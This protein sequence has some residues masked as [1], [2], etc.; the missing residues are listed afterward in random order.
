MADIS[1]YLQKFISVSPALTCPEDQR[2]ARTMQVIILVQ[3]LG[4]LSF[5]AAMFI[6]NASIMPEVTA[7]IEQ[8][9]VSLLIIVPAYV[10]ARTR[11][12]VYGG[13]WLITGF[14]VNMLAVITAT[15]LEHPDHGL[16][17]LSIATF[18]AAVTLPMTLAFG[19]AFITSLLIFLLPFFT[20]YS[21]ELII[22]TLMF[23]TSMSALILAGAALHRHSMRNLELSQKRF[24]DLMEANLESIAVHDNHG[25]IIDVNPAL[26]RL[27]G[28]PRNALIN[29]SILEFVPEWANEFV[30]ELL[31]YDGETYEVEAFNALGELRIV[32]GRTHRQQW[33]GE[34]AYITLVNDI[35]Q[36]KQL[37]HQRIE[38]ERRYRALFD[39]TADAV[40]IVD[41]ESRIIEVN[42]QAC[43][44]LG[45]E[46]GELIHRDTTLILHWDEHGNR[47][48]VV[49]KLLNDEIVPVFERHFVRRDGTLFVG[50]VN[51]TV[52][53]DLDRKPLYFQNIIRDTSARR[54]EQ[55]R[56][57]ELALQGE[58]I[59][60]LE[61]FIGETSHYFR[62]P[63]TNLKTSLYLLSR[64]SDKPEK[65][66]YHRQVIEVEIGRLE[67]LLEDM[68]TITRLQRGDDASLM[69]FNIARN[70]KEVINALQRQNLTYTL[71]LH[72][73]D[74]ND[75]DYKILGDFQRMMQAFSN[76]IENAIQYS[77]PA[78]PIDIHFHQIGTWIAIQIHDQGIGIPEEDMA[79]IFKS[80]YRA[81]NARAI[82]SASSGL[83]LA[84][85]EKIISM[86]RGMIHVDSTVGEG[87]TFSVVLPAATNWDRA[88]E[89]TAGHILTAIQNRV[90]A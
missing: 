20:P 43:D 70:L 12:Y 90:D 59:R 57:F 54:A 31:E 56:Q 24:K 41:M 13:I 21:L 46:A 17:F 80:F 5:L 30:D 33:H 26:E 6:D 25:R 62:T 14:I 76:M 79:H 3:A 16:V 48:R 60:M 74:A 58:K 64:H 55:A 61:D 53:R 68:L 45:Y 27:I 39:Q 86:H 83:G 50:E 9:I 36:R 65:Q 89:K 11:F 85:A 18:I 78:N 87:T 42:Q 19:I 35:T 49:E 4:Q 15:Q 40:I 22:P 47:L 77:D 44:M 51:A 52:V 73:D 34:D 10:L 28:L 23:H 29:R 72:F 71:K 82:D 2:H 63:L 81:D 67:Q 38:I 7:S 1:R 37:E 69:Y 84:I 32:E 8:L 88:N 66:L 75:D